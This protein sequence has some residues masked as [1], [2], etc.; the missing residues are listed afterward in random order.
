MVP[1]FYAMLGLDM[2][3]DRTAIEAALARCQPIWSSGTRNPK[4]KHTYQSYLD[5][6]PR[7]RQALLGDPS[8]RAAYDAELA[9]SRREQ[10]DRSLDELQRLV[11]FRAAKGGLT[12]SDRDLLRSEAARLGVSDEDFERLIEPIPPKPDTPV[13]V[14]R[15]D[16]PIDAI[17]PAVRRQIRLALD[18]LRR[19]D[20]Y[21]VLDLPRDAPAEEIAARA[22][23][24][25]RKWMQKA[26]V[27]A[28]KT[29]WLEAISYVQSHLIAP[30]ARARYD[31]TL[32]VEAEEAFG[33][34]LSFTLRGLRQLDPGTRRIL[35][36]EASGLGITPDRAEILI[37]RACRA[38]G[39]VEAPASPA[40][41]APSAADE[42]HLRCRA[43]AGITTV[44]NTTRRLGAVDCRHCGASLRWDC[45]VC[46]REHFVDQ[47][48]CACGFPLAHRETVLQH[49]EAAQQAFRARDYD[50]SLD[51]LARVQALAPRHTAAAK[52]A[53]RVKARKA[54]VERLRA[55]CELE[56]S[57]RTFSAARGIWNE[58]SRLVDPADPALRAASDTIQRALTEAATL[59]SRAAD[60]ASTDPR[61]ARALYTKALALARDLA[62]AREG[63]LA[64]PPDPPAD[65][66]AR[67]EDGRVRLH[68]SAPPADGLGALSY[69]VVRKRGGPPAHLG[70]G[71]PVGDFVTVECED[72]GIAPGEVLGYAVFAM[73]GGI[74]SIQGAA[75]ARPVIALADVAMVRAEAG[76]RE[77]RLSWS[78]PEGAL[79]VKVVRKA[80]SAPLGPD[81]GEPVETLREQAID[82][83]V[84]DARLY[85]YGIYC[86]Y[87]TPDGGIL[88]S[89]GVTTSAIPHA[90]SDEVGPLQL[91]R[92][93]DQRLR[94][95][96]SGSIR[97]RV[98]VLKS[99][100]PLPFPVGS[101]LAASQVR[102]LNGH[103]LGP[104]ENNH[105][106]DDDPP[107]SGVWYYTPLT[108][109]GETLTVGPCTVFSCVPEP[110]DLRAGRVSAPGRFHLRWRWGADGGSCVVLARQGGFPTG[111]D[112]PAALR[113]PVTETEYSRLGYFVVSLPNELGGP[114]H[115]A[116]YG[117]MT[118]GREPVYSQGL[119]PTSRLVLPGPHPEVTVSYT[120]RPSRIPGRPWSLT[121]RTDPP[122]QTI[123]PTALIGHPRTIPLSVDDGEIVEQF[124]P[125]QDGATLPIRAKRNLGA[126]RL[127]VF[128]DPHVDPKT[129]QP[130]RLR[131]PEPG[132]ARA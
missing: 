8:S 126:Y 122:G 18:H 60:L 105:A 120:V 83:G 123:P 91:T 26:Q 108:A 25:R 30:D 66:Q 95:S 57:R 118:V 114:W 49:F 35:G 94:L 16:P 47:P 80:G 32:I 52:A 13:E 58:W 116:V 31:R 110:S 111:P 103:W 56:I 70:D 109:W 63:L 102:G 124:P 2:E 65:L 62:E 127:R 67:Y 3:A 84:E 59:A 55:A 97:G 93:R 79:G 36:H 48:R 38:S 121:F 43:C 4:T 89:R 71:L 7:I 78:S 11:R 112:D 76:S 130:I 17:E 73:R 6:I 19:P 98:R 34:V 42:R 128:L 85:H 14:E 82:R 51:H 41:K 132:G 29:A 12:V 104:S 90:P 45:P 39:I 64:C 119:D 20:L 68:W 99:P 69:R 75:T 107:A 72:R 21:A 74:A 54:D 113:F 129:L 131:H 100:Q 44:A 86:L 77:V 87:R 37:R 27:T 115:L 24:E 22:D 10:R 33:A 9:A 92:E 5:Q 61:A 117:V 106:F 53:E 28:E 50:G 23:A 46:R 15:P 88:A 40:G 96:W 81:D 101:H 1:D 125:S